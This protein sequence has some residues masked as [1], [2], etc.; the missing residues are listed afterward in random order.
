[1]DRRIIKTKA[2]IKK[3]LAETYSKNP[4]AKMNISVLCEAININRS[5][6]YLH[7]NNIYSV[8]EEFEMEIINGIKSICIENS[9]NIESL[10]EKLCAYIKDNND[11]VKTLLY[12]AQT[13]FLNLMIRECY[14]LA[15]NSYKIKDL[16]PGVTKDYVI[17][18]VITGSFGIFK[19]WIFE[20]YSTK[21]SEVVQGFY[22]FLSL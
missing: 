5:T 21:V 22:D 11:V 3:Y 15:S 18:F 20:N 17:T 2:A 12:V 8:I 9:K 4:N 19:K 14:E 13:H 1:M 16:N 10:I 6:F 7:Y